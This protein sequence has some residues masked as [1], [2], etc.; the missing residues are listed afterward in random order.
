MRW[1][2]QQSLLRKVDFVLM[3]KVSFHLLP[4]RQNSL[5]DRC[6][7]EDGMILMWSNFEVSLIHIFHSVSLKNDREKKVK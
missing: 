2:W 6:Y 1:Q 3:M 7:S 4:R 5:F